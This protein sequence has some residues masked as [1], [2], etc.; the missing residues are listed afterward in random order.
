MSHSKGIAAALADHVVRVLSL[1]H[2]GRGLPTRPGGALGL[3]VAVY[4]L[5]ASAR[6][7]AEASDAML[8]PSL[9]MFP[10]MLAAAAPAGM[11]VQVLCVGLLGSIGTDAIAVGAA[12]AASALSPDWLGWYQF[13]VTATAVARM[14]RRLRVAS[15]PPQV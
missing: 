14:I 1:R 13:A 12:R 6:H 8:L 7:L 3:L 11:I 2:D 4:V 9:V 5:A 10:V 15:P